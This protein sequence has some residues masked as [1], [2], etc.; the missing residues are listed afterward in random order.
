MLKIFSKIPRFIHIL[1]LVGVFLFSTILSFAPLH[2]SAEPNNP[3][4]AD[5][6]EISYEKTLSADEFHKYR[7][8]K[9]GYAPG[10]DCVEKRV[11]KRAFG[12]LNV[13]Y[14]N[15]CWYATKIGLL[16]EQGDYLLQP[17]TSVA[18]HITATHFDSRKWPALKATPNQDV[19]LGLVYDAA[20]SSG[21]YLEF[22][23]IDD[24]H[25]ERTEHATGTVTL[26]LVT[27]PTYTPVSEGVPSYA[28]RYNA[29][30]DD[31][32]WSNDG[33]YLLLAKEGWL[34]RFNLETFK[35]I[36]HTLVKDD[37]SRIRMIS[38][39]SITPSGRYGVL[40]VET[41]G[42]STDIVVI[43]FDSCTVGETEIVNISRTCS[44]K[45]FKE[46]IK[47]ETDFTSIWLPR[48]HGEN[49]LGLY[50]YDKNSPN[51]G[52]RQY[53]LQ[54]F[55]TERTTNNYLALG[56]S[57]SSGE[58]A[59]DYIDDT[60]NKGFNMCH[61][62]L[63]SFPYLIDRRLSLSG[64]KS[65]ACS[66]ADIE[67]Y[68]S[69]IQQNK[70][71]PNSN[72]PGTKEQRSF[73]TTEK[74]SI[75][76]ITMGGNDI[77]FSDRLEY[78]LVW[79]ASCYDTQEERLE[80]VNLIHD[81][82]DDL[83][84]MYKDIINYEDSRR[85]LY[86]VG[87]PQIMNGSSEAKC[88]INVNFNTYQR[89]MANDLITYFNAV[90]KSA[91]AHAGA[92]YVDTEGAL[93]GHRMCDGVSA[94][95]AVN[96][97]TFGDEAVIDNR[98]PVS[99]ASYHPNE[100]GHQLMSSAILDITNGLT[101]PMPLADT[102]TS[103]PEPGDYPFLDVP[104]SGGVVHRSILDR[105][106]DNPVLRRGTGAVVKYKEVLNPF[107]PG[108]YVTMLLKSDPVELGRVQTDKVGMLETI[109]AIPESVEPGLHELRLNGVD[110]YGQPVSVRQFVFVYAEE[111]DYDGDG[112]LNQD[113][114]CIMGRSAGIDIDQDGIDDACD[115]MITPL[116]DT[117]EV[118]H[119]TTTENIVLE[120]PASPSQ[121]AL[122]TVSTVSNSKQE[123]SQLMGLMN[124][125]DPVESAE[126]FASSTPSAF[127]SSGGKGWILGL[128]ALTFATLLSYSVYKYA[129]QDKE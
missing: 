127:V 34:G 38:S 37:Q 10:V 17:G 13:Q 1:L 12:S 14:E 52:F 74:P 114:L 91:A 98:G 78:C 86:V 72:R 46:I 96:G 27:D 43:D 9:T 33:K 35:Y 124:L 30:R 92:F 3:W 16:N 44:T 47:Q 101:E 87:Y 88:A 48:F 32:W 76:T 28:Q 67:N 2:T 115:P 54:A 129:V 58:G 65:V 63:N 102:S 117:K 26:K 59:G 23:K 95:M 85:S 112:I 50:L 21:H 84:R 89:A 123:E 113:E 77:G 100:L 61:T 111:N 11:A 19:L 31:M 53:F 122:T 6:P 69:V 25:F 39:A 62:S 18:G 41:D 103:I 42:S 57:F 126:G 64:F 55:G 125:K 94:F 7:D 68:T 79:S 40:A 93:D 22:Y 106:V 15:S 119:E 105:I 45:S 104:S 29:R 70:D 108:S 99:K 49:T 97:L 60:D 128:V 24:M 71:D 90:I 109:V 8:G 118:D 80:V 56:D 66:G 107:S 110:E 4:F 120:T 51:R 20:A 36:G 81:H 75:V 121:T 5:E 116:S 83:V 82:H 73:L